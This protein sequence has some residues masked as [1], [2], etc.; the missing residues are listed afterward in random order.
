MN[1]SERTGD[2]VRMVTCQFLS[3]VSTEQP[4]DGPILLLSLDADS[5]LAGPCRVRKLSKYQL[6]ELSFA[7]LVSVV[8]SFFVMF[9]LPHQTQRVV[10]DAPQQV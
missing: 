1:P 3:L 7:N 6:N 8:W 2:Q 4:R 9:A 10:L 5:S